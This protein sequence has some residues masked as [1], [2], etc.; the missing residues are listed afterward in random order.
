MTGE[1]A[2]ARSMEHDWGMGLHHLAASILGMLKEMQALAV[3]W[4]LSVAVPQMSTR[5]SPSVRSS[6]E[7]RLGYPK[8]SASTSPSL[9]SD[10]LSLLHQ[11]AQG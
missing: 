8:F 9:P 10:H 3:Q 6:T 7:G 4:S 11:V 1:A 2:V 5:L